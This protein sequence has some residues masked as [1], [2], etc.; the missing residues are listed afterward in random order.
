MISLSSASSTS[1][2]VAARRAIEGLTRA[3]VAGI[4]A[5]AALD[6]G[7]GGK[8]RGDAEKRAPP[9]RANEIGVEARF[10]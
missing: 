5:E 10:P 7:R 8:L 6:V 4:D 9:D 1:R 3:R 2:L